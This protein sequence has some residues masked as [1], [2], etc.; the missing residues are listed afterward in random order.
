MLLQEAKTQ[1]TQMEVLQHSL[2]PDELHPVAL[3]AED[4]VAEALVGVNDLEKVE[5]WK[6]DALVPVWGFLAVMALLFWAKRRQL[7]RKGR[8]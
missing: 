3:R 4:A 2:S 5:R 6:R 1:I 7:E 8:P